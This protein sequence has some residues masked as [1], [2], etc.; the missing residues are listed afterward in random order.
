MKKII[1]IL[2]AV[3]LLSIGCSQSIDI[4]EPRYVSP[5]K[6]EQIS[7]KQLKE[8]YPYYTD[9]SCKE[10]KEKLLYISPTEYE[11]LSCNQLHEQLVKIDKRL[12]MKSKIK[13][14]NTVGMGIFIPFYMLTTAGVPAIM[15]AASDSDSSSDITPQK[16]S[17]TEIL[18]N[19]HET[20]KKVANK[21]NCSFASDM[22]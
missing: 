14:E 15:H 17:E 6:Y 5:I 22:K 9:I 21:K 10:L 3:A 11:K 8:E 20:L 13:V 19:A 16:I 18:K 4:A 2:G 12:D 7:C 1:S